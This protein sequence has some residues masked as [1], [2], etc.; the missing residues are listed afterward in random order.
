MNV[1]QESLEAYDT[2]ALTERQREVLAAV[3]ALHSEGR[4]PC[5][6]DIADR[7]GWAINRITGRR[8]ELEA[9]GKIVQ[10]GRKLNAN[11]NRVKV[12]MP[13]PKQLEFP[14]APARAEAR[15]R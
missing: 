14:L 2:V 8:G 3:V 4:R 15:A 10:A 1:A 12:W 11:G 5:D 6:Q 7:L 13:V 9:A